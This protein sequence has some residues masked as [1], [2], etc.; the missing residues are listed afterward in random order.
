M[1][2]RQTRVL[3]FANNKGGSGK[4]TTCSN[5]GYALASMGYRVLMVDGDMQLNLSLAFFSEEEVLAMAQSEKNLYYAVKNQRDLID[6]IVHTPYEGLDLIPSSTLMSGIEYELFTKWQRELILQKGLKTIRAQGEYDYVLIDS[7]PTLGG[8]VLNI[9]CASD[10]IMIPV[11]A[12]PWG[13]FGLANMFEFL[14]E[15]REMTPQLKLLGVAITKV[16][17]RKNYFRQTLDTLHEMSE[18]PVFDS[19]IRVDSTVEWA[20]DE[21]KPVL[22]YRRNSRSAQE[23]LTMT[24]EVL[25]RWQ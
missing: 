18:V 9:L 20:Q 12:S 5:I 4:T 21:S 10:G 19:Y 6:Y 22:A 16:D 8:W 15:V 25:Q 11:E 1:E 7:P 2:G 17:T 24:K 3:C 14:E 23:Y 13:L